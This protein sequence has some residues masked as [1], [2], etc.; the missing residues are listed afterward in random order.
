M[1]LSLDLGFI[2]RSALRWQEAVAACGASLCSETS[3]GSRQVCIMN[4]QSAPFLFFMR[5]FRDFQSVCKNV[6]TS[7]RLWIFS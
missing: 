2:S 7:Q 6:R 3:G 4:K 1:K 5:V